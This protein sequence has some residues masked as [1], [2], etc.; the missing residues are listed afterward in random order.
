[1]AEEL[2]LYANKADWQVKTE[3][4]PN[5]TYVIK[6]DPNTQWSYAPGAST[7][8]RGTEVVAGDKTHLGGASTRV[9]G[10]NVLVFHHAPA[11]DIPDKSH[12]LNGQ[13]YRFIRTSSHGAS[14]FLGHGDL[15]DSTADNSGTCK[16]TVAKDAA[17]LLR[18]RVELPAKATK[19]FST[20]TI[21]AAGGVKAEMTYTVGPGF[22]TKRYT[23]AAVIE[24]V[25]G[26]TDSRLVTK[27]I[28]R[29][30]PKPLGTTKTGTDV[31]DLASISLERVD[32]VR[33]IYS[34]NWVEASDGTARDYIRR[35]EDDIKESKRTYKRL[36]EEAVGLNLITK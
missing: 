35:L 21:D 24:F 34:N 36:E 15:I 11:G 30:A 27:E 18:F 14:L 23:T 12:F 1:M 7:D 26:S 32:L 22:G 4:E 6:P 25:D 8:F 19:G 13:N 20:W 16:V 10:V 17:D 33:R 3:L 28:G 31:T 29:P 2:T 5:S 9:G